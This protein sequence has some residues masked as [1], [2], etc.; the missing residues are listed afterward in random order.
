MVFLNSLLIAGSPLAQ[1]QCNLWTPKLI[2]LNGTAECLTMLTC[3]FVAGAIAYYAQQ[4][5]DLSIENISLLI[6]SFFIFIGSG[7]TQLSDLITIWYPNYWICGI[8][9]ALNAGWLTYFFCFLLI[10]LIPV[11]LDAPSA[12]QLE[13]ANVALAIEI[14]ERKRVEEDIRILNAELET[15][16][17]ERTK[18]L[19]SSNAKLEAEDKELKQAE[20]KL[21]AYNAKL[22]RS[23]RELEEFAYIASHDLQEPLRKIQAFGDRL[24]T[25]FGEALSDRGRD[26]LE[27]MQNAAVRMQDLINDLLTFSRIASQVQPF[28]NINL[29]EIIKEVVSDLE[30]QIE[31]VGGRI[32]VAD[33][34]IIEADRLQMRQLFQNLIS[35]ALKFH[36]P[37]EPPAIEIY[38]KILQGEERNLAEGTTGK[39]FCQIDRLVQ[40]T[41]AD[42]GIGFD[43]KYRDRIF[44]IFQRLHGRS[45]YEGTGVGLAICRKIVEHHSG[46]ITIAST[47]GQG[48][49]FTVTLPVKQLENHE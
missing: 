48:S 29:T 3:Y 44:G 47:I 42:N 15:R 41:V 39:D 2:W 21:K 28:A 16:V 25:Q 32:E 7:T 34:S 20:E 38:S 9:K 8:V 36:R 45:E 14:S 40:I 4:R 24:Q 5:K 35:N 19:L 49:T 26:Y 17:K 37:D 18:E 12:A 23:N 6:G 13:A 33:L 46:R 11:A 30:A 1:E 10:P 43:E 22:E 31:R 27:R